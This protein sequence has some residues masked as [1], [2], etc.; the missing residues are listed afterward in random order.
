MLKPLCAVKHWVFDLD[1][2]LTCDV[3]DFAYVRQEL[4][5]PATADIIHYLA[6]LPAA[7]AQAKQA[8]LLAYERAQAALTQPAI[9]AVE[10]VQWL[11]QRGYKLAILTRNTRELAID[12]LTSLGLLAYFSPSNILGREQGPAKPNPAGL[13]ALAR[14]WCVTPQQMAMVGDFHFDLNCAKA[15]GAIAI[16]V[17]NSTNQWPEITDLY[18]S[19]CAALLAILKDKHK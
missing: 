1:G 5:I 14:Q 18:L 6:S 3:H 4:N 12:T 11:A 7:E 13:L 17:N 19:D 16:Q 10:L 8:W 15:A 2:T 9:G